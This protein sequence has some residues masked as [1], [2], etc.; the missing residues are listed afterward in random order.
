MNN[1]SQ[2]L[3][4]ADVQLPTGVRLRYAEQG[5]PAGP[6]LILLHGLTDS[7]FS[8]SPVLPALAARHHVYALDQRGH[9]DSGR[10]AQG[11]AMAD[12]AADV[13][14]FMDAMDLPQA[15]LAGHSMSTFV[16]LEAAGTAPGRVTRL[17]LIGG[18]ASP[19]NA[20]TEELL[21]MFADLTDP[22]PVELAREFQVGTTHT[23]LDPAF[24]ERVVGESR[25]VPARVWRDALAGM[26]A[27]DSAARLG[28]I[29]A[30]TLLLWGEQDTIFGR[31]DQEALLA[32]L[33]QAT[34][35]A[36]PAT[37]HALH[38]ERPAQ[39]AQDL[40]DFVAE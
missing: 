36:Y 17:A 31:A 7:W 40:G 1:D 12:F 33:A 23:P 5:D 10:P 13:L 35:K 38:W 9:G 27:C 22:V 26:L 6:P 4:F 20:V 32:G 11:Y 30:P 39:A 14:A 8:F 19:R 3:R 24:L 29:S 16:A 37:G 15:A 28:Q 25:K 2:P 21:G 18:A 34:L